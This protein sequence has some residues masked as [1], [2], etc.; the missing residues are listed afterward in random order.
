MITVNTILMVLGFLLA[1]ALAI[2]ILK[3]FLK[4]IYKLAPSV[5][6]VI[7]VSFGLYYTGAIPKE[8]VQL[9]KE[10]WSGRTAETIE[11]KSRGSAC[12]DEQCYDEILPTASP[13][14]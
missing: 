4:S 12:R 11:D 1:G 3:S 9:L 14:R 2:R 6:I 8:D 7:V 10:R 13:W 5:A